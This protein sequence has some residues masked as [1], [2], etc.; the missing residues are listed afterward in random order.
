MTDQTVAIDDHDPL[1]FAES[2][3][4][5]GR[6]VAVATVI[7]TWGSAPRPVGGVGFGRLR[8]G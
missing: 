2:A 4:R 1:A 8:R 7:E 6:G 3:M 5:A